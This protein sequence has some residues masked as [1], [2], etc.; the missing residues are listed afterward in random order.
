[1][2]KIILLVLFF[3]LYGVLL[4]DK[5]TQKISLEQCQKMAKEYY[6]LSKEK[7]FLLEQNNLKLEN[8]QKNWWPQVS[9]NSQ[10]SYQSDVSKLPLKLP[11]IPGFNIEL[12]EEPDKDKYS[13]TLDIKQTIYDGNLTKSLKNQQSSRTE[14]DIASN[15]T[16]LYKIRDIVNDLYFSILL[17]DAKQNILENSLTDLNDKME[18][19]KSGIRNGTV[20]QMQAD[21]LEAEILNL[22]QQIGE[23]KTNRHS[24]VK[25]LSVYTGDNYDENVKLM[26]PDV[27]ITNKLINNRPEFNQFDLEKRFIRSSSDILD[28]KKMPKVSLFGQ[29]GYSKPGLDMFKNEFDAYAIGGVKAVWDIT[30]FY[31]SRNE[32]QLLSI[33]KDLV[34]VKKETF[35]KNL[36][37]ALVKL[38]S[39]IE[40]FEN[41]LKT[42]ESIVSLN[43]N[44]IKTAE[45][46]LINGVIN[47]IDYIGYTNRLT[48]SK[49]NMK[50]HEIM[51]LQAKI[52]YKTTQGEL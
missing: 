18:I 4:A 40:N 21:V 36:D 15:E 35:T 46:Q 34:D 50:N 10:I 30:V 41:L 39:R 8:L 51:L 11:E 31:T 3:L 24:F 48:N 14:A 33:G 5:I 22:N 37:A 7:E 20:L 45:S 9:L 2:R 47:S 13:L 28:S 1:M 27:V 29:L 23:T 32:N 25:S 44:I 6:P 16:E 26:I 38:Y 42:D 49:L 43:E 17:M 12:P 52:N 19:L